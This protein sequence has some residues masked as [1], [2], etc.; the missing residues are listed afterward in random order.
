MRLHI[1][2]VTALTLLLTPVPASAAGDDSG[3]RP[4]QRDRAAAPASPAARSGEGTATPGRLPAV[5]RNMELVSKLNPRGP[6]GPVEP[7]QIADVAVHKD[8]AYLMSWGDPDGTAAGGDPACRRGG[9]FTVDI[10]DPRSPRE[11]NFV[12]ALPGTYHGEGA[13]ALSINTP[14]FRGDLLAVNNEPCADQGTGGFDLYDVSDP[15][16]PK[17]LVRGAGDKTPGADSLANDPAKKANSAHSIFAWQEGPRAY[18]IIV[19]NTEAT[20]VDIFDITDPRNPEFI[21]DLDLASELGVDL[22]GG[23]TLNGEVLHHDL[24][25]K[26][27]N[28]RQIALI[29]YWDSGYVQVDVTDP[30]NPK[31][32]RDS[33]FFGPDPLTGLT[34]Q[35]GNAHQA[36]FSFD[37]RFILAADE[38]FAPLRIDQLTISDGPN[39]GTVPA[40]AIGGGAPPT[41]LPD[42]RI[43]GPTRYVGYACNASKP[44]P[45]PTGM[46]KAAGEELIAVVQR[47]PSG[48]PANPEEACFP[49]EKAENARKAGYE[50]VVFTNRH[51]SDPAVANFPNCG[52]GGFVSAVAVVC[53]GHDV[54]HRI[55]GSTTAEPT[56]GQ[57]GARVNAAGRF[58]GWG[59]TR[60]LSAGTGREIAA[61]AIPEA[62]DP[63]YASGFGDLSVHEFATDPDTNLAYA[64]YYAGGMRV[65]SFGVEGLTEQGAFIDD[66]GA[67]FWGVEQFTSSRDGCRYIAGS[68]R[69][70]GLYVLR[71]TGPGA[72]ACRPPAVTP[73]PPPPAAATPAVTALRLGAFPRSRNGVSTTSTV[74][75]A[76]RLQAKLTVTV[77]GRKFS[78]GTASAAVPRAGTYPLRVRISVI[79][80]RA[81]RARL[82]RAPGRRL[83]GTVRVTFTPATGTRSVLTRRLT[84]R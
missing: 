13:Q 77:R 80:Q 42:G 29:S 28:G 67:N 32:I 12:A 23:E 33:D 60:L 14:A 34:P 59:Y 71:Y 3:E 62:L 76:G 36:E 70:F 35:E 18:A 55:F 65:M 8:H 16:S 21:N 56:L 4:W 50:A 37:N 53:V 69:D 1:A 57:D 30:R 68:D 11:L 72:V 19:D 58:D 74:T 48:D 79:T 46:T 81:L 51:F 17:A 15:A 73:P 9:F 5:R 27:I 63:R 49:G 43:N 25:V 6:F 24:V 84:I 22:K 31:H 78:L 10:R 52:S 64:A 45:A 26:R 2:R 38:D 66:R 54:L 7:E 44:V 75:G 20:D 40:A 39:A 61:Y 83:T 41:I 47:G 82:A